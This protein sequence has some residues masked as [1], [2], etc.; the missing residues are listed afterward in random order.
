MVVIC[1]HILEKLV[2][3]IVS[4]RSSVRCDVFL[5]DISSDSAH[6]AGASIN[7]Q[8]TW[9]CALKNLQVTLR[10]NVH[11]PQLLRELLLRSNHED[12]RYTNCFLTSW[13]LNTTL[14]LR[15][16]IH[17]AMLPLVLIQPARYAI[18]HQPHDCHTLI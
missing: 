1:V 18:E 4:M 12:V 9:C 16:I 14:T 11:A 13:A 8:E 2:S 3:S 10:E 5:L 15:H 6:R 17:P 7:P